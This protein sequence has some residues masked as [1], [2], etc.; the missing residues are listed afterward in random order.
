MSEKPRTAYSVKEKSGDV[1]G[2]IDALGI[3]RAVVVGHSM[4]AGIAA[5]VAAKHSE[6]VYGLAIL[7]KSPNGPKMC[8]ILQPEEIEVIDPI[9]KD[10]PMPFS[11]RAEPGL[12]IYRDMESEYGRRHCENSLEEKA[13]GSYMMY[14]TYEIAANIANYEE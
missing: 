12:Y 2:L 3:D 1:I 5:H 11:S 10:W 4:E 13:D 6:R 14:S 7:D 9:S 8:G